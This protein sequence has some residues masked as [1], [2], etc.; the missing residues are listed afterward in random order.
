M[1]SAREKEK[2]RV[3]SRAHVITAGSIGILRV[4]VQSQKEP[5]RVEEKLRVSQKEKGRVEDSKEHAT[6]AGST[7]I[8][9]TTARKERAKARASLD[10]RVKADGEE[11]EKGLV[12]LTIGRVIL[13]IREE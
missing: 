12:W 4:I 5:G 7:A 1:Q 6:H 3:D 2:E 10:G 8:L 13:G 11:Q 9:G